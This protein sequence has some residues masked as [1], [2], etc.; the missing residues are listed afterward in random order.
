MHQLAPSGAWTK[1]CVDL[2]FIINWRRLNA[3][4]LKYNINFKRKHSSEPITLKTGKTATFRFK[5]A[6]VRVIAFTAINEHN[7]SNMS[8]I[9]SCK[10]QKYKKIVPKP[11]ETEQFKTPSKRKQRKRSCPNDTPTRPQEKPAKR[12]I[13]F[14]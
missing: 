13:M 1:S 10:S 4:Q 2:W 7:T 9:I 3:A 12:Q 11:Q 8:I 14:Q 6:K 5:D